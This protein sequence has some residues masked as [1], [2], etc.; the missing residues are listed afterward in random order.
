MAAKATARRNRDKKI[1]DLPA[2]KLTMQNGAIKHKLN[3]LRH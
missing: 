2:Q 1:Q 3:S